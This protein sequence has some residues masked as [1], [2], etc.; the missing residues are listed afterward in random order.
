MNSYGTSQVSLVIKNPPASVQEVLEMRVRS[1]SWEDPCLEE[2]VPQ[3]SILA[4]KIPQTEE[5]GGLQ[6]M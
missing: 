1:L 4:W 3:F 5:P 6:S 2:M